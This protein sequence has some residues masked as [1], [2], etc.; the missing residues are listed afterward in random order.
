M[1]GG[2]FNLIYIAPYSTLTVPFS[3]CHARI[4]QPLHQVIGF[5]ELLTQTTLTNQQKEYVKFLETSAKSL[6]TVINDALDCTKI[7]A[8]KMVFENIPFEV[9]DLIAGVSAA[10]LP[11]AES[12]N[13]T[14]TLGV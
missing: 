1:I 9:K 5:I 2:F 8:G 7:E 10:I 3:L 14:I 6:M 4:K 12:K 11:K 13:L